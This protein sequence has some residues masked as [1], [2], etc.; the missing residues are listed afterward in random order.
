LPCDV[1]LIFWRGWTSGV[2]SRTFLKGNFRDRKHCGGLPSS[3]F[4]RL[5][6]DE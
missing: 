6:F 1:I 4:V 3:H 2:P 5:A